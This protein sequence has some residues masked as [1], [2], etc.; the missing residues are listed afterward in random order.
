[1]VRTEQRQLITGAG[2]CSRRRRTIQGCRLEGPDGLGEVLETRGWMTA[3]AAGLETRLK[4]T[5]RCRS[6][7]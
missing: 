6:L 3:A 7:S 2:G 4:L 5:T 1:V